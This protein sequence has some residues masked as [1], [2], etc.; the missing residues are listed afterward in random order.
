MAMLLTE[1]SFCFG[2]YVFFLVLVWAFC[3]CEIE[4]I[5]SQFFVEMF[6]GDQWRFLVDSL[7]SPFFFNGWEITPC[8]KL[9]HSFVAE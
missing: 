7:I 9:A 3:F 6:V 5:M 1:N 8:S 2:V 4:K